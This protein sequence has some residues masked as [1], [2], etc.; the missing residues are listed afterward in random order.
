MK[1]FRNRTSLP[2]MTTTKCLEEYV[3]KR[4]PIW[5]SWR[6][7]VVIL[8]SLLLDRTK[9]QNMK[10]CKAKYGTKTKVD[11]RSPDAQHHI[12]RPFEAPHLPPHGI[13]A[14]ACFIGCDIRCETH[15][16]LRF[17]SPVFTGKRPVFTLHFAGVYWQASTADQ[18][19]CFGTRI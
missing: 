6:L 1:P 10:V 7:W 18:A 11:C 16:V 2:T 15:P 8:L 5:V 3:C 13:T 9:A 4:D 14:L 12:H 17:N 19:K